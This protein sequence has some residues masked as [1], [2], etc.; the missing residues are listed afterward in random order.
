MNILVTGATG[1]IASH[2]L[3][4]LDQQGWQIVAALRSPR[5]L[6]VKT[7]I[8]GNIDGNTDWQDALKDIDVVI[9]LA[10]RAHILNDRQN[11]E[12]EFFRVNTEGTANLIKQS[13]GAGVKRFIFISSIGAMATL[14]SQVLTESSPCRPD[15]AYGRSKLWAEQEL[16]ELA[17]NSNMTWTILRPPLVY[18]FGNPG[19]MERLMKLIKRGLPLPFGAIEN[20]RS[21]IFVGNLVDAIA[22]CLSHPQAA[23]QV[24]LVSDGTDLSTPQ[25]VRL[26]AQQMQ[27]PCQLLPIPPRF[28][29]VAAVVGDSWQHLSKQPI[30]INTA[31]V[32]R[33]T[34]S[35][36]VDISHTQNTLKWHPPFTIEQGIEQTLKS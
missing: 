28:L 21:F 6:P 11:P 24:F 30:A 13:I 16:V 22:T 17:Q 10:A 12:A 8:V 35:L 32:D 23:N 14:S 4:R 29:K 34:G 1:F 3:P 25:L 26:I 31:T 2:L 9:H 33:L 18:G 5:P 7:I 19:N 36:S 20:R 15:T 27:R